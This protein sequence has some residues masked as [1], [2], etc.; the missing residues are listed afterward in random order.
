MFKNH[1]MNELELDPIEYKPEP[2]FAA[3]GGFK[4][5]YKVK[6]EIESRFDVNAQTIDTFDKEL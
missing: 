3:E 6:Q 4:P 1:M 5:K 2:Y